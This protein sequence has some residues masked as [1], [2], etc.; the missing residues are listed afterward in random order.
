MDSVIEQHLRIWAQK[1]ALGLYYKREIFDRMM[2]FMAP[3]KTLEIGSGPGF[4]KQYSPEIISSDILPLDHLDLV[5][6]SHHLPFG[7]GTLGNVVGIDIIHHF[8]NPALYFN[9]AERVLKRA[10]RIILVEPWITPGSRFVYTYLH[11]EA[12][13]PVAD[14]FLNTFHEEDKDPWSGNMMLPYLLFRKFTGSFV[15]RWPNLNIV[16][17]ETFAT[18]AYLL[19]GGFRRFGVRS[20]KGMACLLSIERML[21]PLLDPIAAHRALIVLEK[22]K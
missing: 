16:R 22:I 20:E 18:F 15:A 2:S 11:H 9:E 8:R 4:F 5:C 21:R 13:E 19:S 10:G 1:K 7:D 3:G 6:D 12:C 14:P 17:I